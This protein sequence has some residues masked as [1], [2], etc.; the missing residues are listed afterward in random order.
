MK[1]VSFLW[2]LLIIN[3]QLAAIPLPKV[4]QTNTI[5][6]NYFIDADKDGYPADEDCDDNN[7][8]IHPNAKEIPNNDIDENCDGVAIIIDND[9]DGY[10]SDIDCDDLNARIH[11]NAKE[12]A[13]NGKDENCDGKDLVAK[14]LLPKKRKVSIFP[15]EE[16]DLIIIQVG[17]ILRKAIDI[18]VTGSEGK[19]MAQKQLDPGRTIIHVDATTYY[20]GEY[21]IQLDD[22]QEVSLHKVIIFKE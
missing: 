1:I 3:I 10:N 6:C 22:G 17:G 15:N 9:K 13:N 14:L 16:N 18:T 12:I 19:I 7:P 4:I 2:L 21:Q 5:S 8:N 11:P 20:N